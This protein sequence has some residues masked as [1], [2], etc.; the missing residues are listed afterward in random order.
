MDGGT[1]VHIEG[2]PLYKKA[3][4]TEQTEAA[5]AVLALIEALP[6]TDELAAVDT[7]GEGFAAYLE[8]LKAN[9]LAARSA[10]DAL[11]DADKAAFDPAALETLTALE[12]VL[13]SMPVTMASETT[14]TVSTWDDLRKAV[15]D[16]APIG[17]TIKLTRIIPTSEVTGG[18]IEVDEKNVVI[19]GG[20]FQGEAKKL[21][22]VTVSNYEGSAVLTLKNFHVDGQN[23]SSSATSVISLDD[24][25]T[26][27]IEDG[28]IFENIKIKGRDY[29]GIIKNDAGT[30]VVNGGVFQN[31]TCEAATLNDAICI[32]NGGVSQLEI[33]GGTFSNNASASGTRPVIYS[34]S[35]TRFTI[36]G[37]TFESSNK[38]G[39]YI[40]AHEKALGDVQLGMRLQ[41][42]PTINC[43]IYLATSEE[44]PENFIVTTDKLTGGSLV[45]KPQ[46]YKEG[47][48]LV[49]GRYNGY[50]FTEEECARI[51]LAAAPDGSTWYAKLSDD[52][53]SI[54]ATKSSGERLYVLYLDPVN[55]D[56]T[57]NGQMIGTAI[58]TFERARQLLANGGKIILV[59]P[60]TISDSQLW[61]LPQNVFG[62]ETVVTD[63][64]TTSITV[65]GSL[66]LGNIALEGIDRFVVKSGGKLTI[67]NSTVIKS[68]TDIV[69][70]N[71]GTLNIGANFDAGAM[72]KIYTVGGGTV[73]SNGN[74]AANGK[75]DST[76]QPPSLEDVSP[77]EDQCTIKVNSSPY[78][79]GGATLQEAVTEAGGADAITK[80]TI[81]RG[82]MTEA[83]W[84]YLKNLTAL[85]DFTVNAA[86][87]EG[88][89]VP[90]GTAGQA[91]FPASIQTVSMANATAIGDD[92]FSGCTA[93]TTVTA[94][95]VTS[96]GANAF[97]GCTQFAALTLSALIPT[98]GANAFQDCA[99]L[100][101]V[102]LVD[103]SGTAL[104]GETL[105]LAQKNYDEVTDGIVGSTAHDG[106]W[107]GWK[108]RDMIEAEWTV[109]GQRHHLPRPHI[110]RDQDL[111]R[112]LA[113]R[114]RRHHQ[115][116]AKR[117]IRMDGM[118]V[119][120]P[121]N[122]PR[123]ER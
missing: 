117:F 49:K 29:S 66:N 68:G 2:C 41:G 36:R 57:K 78:P 30:C 77:V 19:D 55:G 88:V 118:S 50:V 106:L 52:K 65:A 81:I 79:Y 25:A 100:R 39:I 21:F 4:E 83:D 16:A 47:T 86:I 43:P 10:Y 64:L 53:E 113:K 15:E 71:G 38:N 33:Y 114:E 96:I 112:C 12:D 8:T 95:A 109:M 119:F 63:K 22:T 37:G 20:G 14:V 85:T 3:A 97:R 42:N 111:P 17:T 60:I 120:L 27:I 48:V 90:S 62:S 87:T 31:N 67:G 108:V 32:N 89:N 103:A 104:T 107:Y 23:L 45:V 80:L 69:V 115:V 18:A 84:T 9:V 54:V 11:T 73:N 82:V 46:E 122:H 101:A 5:K 34:S 123:L 59:P 61:E 74:T 44:I 7:E 75:I 91:V 98:V 92:A 70:E 105:T 24:R 51:K 72:G 13:A 93:L 35:K 99:A 121:A 28:C 26:L 58:K 6:T 1:V 40:S 76:T 56:D 94:P 116:D 102:T 110:R